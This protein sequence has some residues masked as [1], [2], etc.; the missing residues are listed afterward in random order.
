MQKLR[1][2]TRIV[3]EF[4][5][6]WEESL[7]TMGSSKRDRTEE[8]SNPVKKRL[9]NGRERKHVWIQVCALGAARGTEPANAGHSGDR[10]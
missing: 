3:L 2:I 5:T 10:I 4:K 6:A 1:Q 8:N 9:L 7:P